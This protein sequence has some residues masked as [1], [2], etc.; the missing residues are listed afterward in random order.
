MFGKEKKCCFTGEEKSESG[1]PCRSKQNEKHIAD[2][3]S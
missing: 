3:E 2:R 1:Y